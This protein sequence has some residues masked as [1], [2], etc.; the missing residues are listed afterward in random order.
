MNM[1]WC[2]PDDLLF[3]KKPEH[4]TFSLCLVLV[5]VLSVTHKIIIHCIDQV[6][7][8]PG[9]KLNIMWLYWYNY[10]LL[11]KR[12]EKKVTMYKAHSNWLRDVLFLL[13]DSVSRFGLVV[14]C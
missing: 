6:V 14:R 10:N 7:Y 11:L 12:K 8:L 1:Y 9:L 4:L 3:F 13:L 2:S 5:V